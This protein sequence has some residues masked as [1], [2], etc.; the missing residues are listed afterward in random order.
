[1]W[2]KAECSVRSG[3]YSCMLHSFK[4]KIYSDG[5]SPGKGVPRSGIMGGKKEMHA[6]YNMKAQKISAGV[7]LGYLR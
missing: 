2:L 4:M 3:K 6:I 7:V 1:M 5:S